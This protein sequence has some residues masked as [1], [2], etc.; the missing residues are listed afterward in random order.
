MERGGVFGEDG[1]E[2]G[3]IYCQTGVILNRIALEI[4][5]AQLPS[6]EEEA[7]TQYAFIGEDK[8]EDGI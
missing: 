5:C 2:G 7:S 1:T 6:G 8:V 4:S 3:K